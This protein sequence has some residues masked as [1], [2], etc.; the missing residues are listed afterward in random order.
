[1]RFGELL[2]YFRETAPFPFTIQLGGYQDRDY[3]FTSRHDR[4][5]ERS[6]SVQG[7]KAVIMGW[8]VLGDPNVA[9]PQD[10]S[11]LIVES[12]RYPG[13]LDDLRRRCQC[14]GVLHGWHRDPKD[15]DNDFYLRI[16]LFEPAAV[17]QTL[18]DALKTEIQ[19]YLT[20]LDPIPVLEV[21][22]ADVFVVGYERETLPL[23]TSSAWSLADPRVDELFV[24][25]L[26]A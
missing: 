23:E 25:N 4:P 15:V 20:N 3:P 11:S 18:T 10:S 21:T 22:L 24:R 13:V 8:P 1:M 14:F 2:T 16:G 17:P 7:D 26:Y 5:Y 12:R 6:F 9:L 19:T